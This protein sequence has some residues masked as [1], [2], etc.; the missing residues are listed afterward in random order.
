MKRS[1]F[2]P[3]EESRPE[4]NFPYHREHMASPL[5]RPIGHYHVRKQSLFILR[6][7]A[8]SRKVAGSILGEVIGFFNWPNPSGS[9]MTPWVDPASNRNEYQESSLVVKG[10]QRVRLTTTPL[11]V[12]RLSRKCR[13]LDVSQPYGPPRPVRGK[14]LTFIE[15]LPASFLVGRISSLQAVVI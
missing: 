12:C 3:A 8:T 6:H 2:P 13:T 10:G 11:S 14:S 1:P 15:A 9:T 5:L 4:I 7:Y